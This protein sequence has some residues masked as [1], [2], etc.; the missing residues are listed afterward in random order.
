MTSGKAKVRNFDKTRW[1]VENIFWKSCKNNAFNIVFNAGLAVG[2][3]L[4]SS[5]IKENKNDLEMAA[6]MW[7][8]TSAIFR[9]FMFI[10]SMIYIHQILPVASVSITFYGYT[11]CGFLTMLAFIRDRKKLYKATKN[12]MH[13]STVLNPGAYIGCKYI[14]FYLLTYFAS[15]FILAVVTSVFVFH[16]QR[17]YYGDTIYVPSFIPENSK[18]S[19][20]NFAG[21]C[22]ISTFG[23][24][25]SASGYVFL[26]CS[27]LYETLAGLI[28]VYGE[29]LK[30]RSERMAWNVETIPDDINMF[31][32]IAF[33]IHEVDDAVN[34]YVFFLYGTLISGFFNTVSVIVAQN[35]LFKTTSSIIYIIWIVTT[36]TLVL[37]GMS[38]HGSNI[39]DKGEE[40]KRQMVEYSDKFI[41][42]SPSLSAMQVFN[43]LFDIITKTNMTIT[44]G[45]MFIINYGLILTIASVMVTYGVLILQL[46]QK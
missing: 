43:I 35:L 16:D 22:V 33:R 25:V 6:K 10:I 46:D 8:W 34:M 11:V 18:Q 4:S 27:N 12:L 24:S 17:D 45:G 38:Y 2:L 23:L 32:H 21:F 26:L 30:K 44:G 37:L 42:Y 31:K 1:R 29:K 39:Y 3:P 19:F 41:R 9:T 20:R 28:S 40:V 36:A 14:N 7:C 5:I 15:I 13:L